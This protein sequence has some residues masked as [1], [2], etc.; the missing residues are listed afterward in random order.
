MLYNTFLAATGGA[1]YSSCDK[2]IFKSSY[3]ETVLSV[4]FVL[5]IV[6]DDAYIVPRAGTGVFVPVARGFPDALAGSLYDKKLLL[7]KRTCNKW[8]WLHLICHGF[9]V[10]PSPQGEGFI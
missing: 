1:G 4:C 2:M 3:R 7:C 9:A 6:G 10:L 5:Q 8:H